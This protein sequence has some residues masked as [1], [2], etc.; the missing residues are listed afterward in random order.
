[1]D[2]KI[3]FSAAF[4]AA[5]TAAPGLGNALAMPDSPVVASAQSIGTAAT[6]IDWRYRYR[7]GRHERYWFGPEVVGHLLRQF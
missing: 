3:L 6:Q 7:H 4:L 5:M 2:I 1:M